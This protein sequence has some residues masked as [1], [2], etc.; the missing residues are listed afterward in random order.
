MHQ[1]QLHGRVS[2]QLHST[3]QDRH[4]NNNYVDDV[5]CRPI[6]AQLTVFLCNLLVSVDHTGS[7]ENIVSTLV[8]AVS[9]YVCVIVK[10][11]SI[12]AY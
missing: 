5:V 4:N 7:A 11:K 8:A 6:Y 9:T 10:L 2:G 3:T 1:S 12:H